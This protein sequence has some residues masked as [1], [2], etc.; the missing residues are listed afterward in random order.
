MKITAKMTKDVLG[1]LDDLIL[2]IQ[3]EQKKP[4]PYA[5]WERKRKK[6]KEKLKKLPEYVEK[7]AS[8]VELNLAT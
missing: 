3:K 5:E 8:M 4:Y 1:V 6:V 7:A 2:E